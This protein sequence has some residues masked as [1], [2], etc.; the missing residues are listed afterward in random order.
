MGNCWPVLGWAGR[1][2]QVT[3]PTSTLLVL[4]TIRTTWSPYRAGL[5]TAAPLSSRISV[6]R[7]PG[8]GGENSQCSLA[9]PTAPA[10]KVIRATRKSP[11]AEGLARA[12][13]AKAID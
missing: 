13:E 3:C 12:L 10:Q 4:G 11:V 7:V 1:P 6:W 5:L 8:A 9:V 2:C